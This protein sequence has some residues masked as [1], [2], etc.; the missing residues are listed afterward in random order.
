VWTVLAEDLSLI[1]APLLGGSQLS[2]STALWE[3]DVSGLPG[4]LH[5]CVFVC[6]CV[7]VCVCVLVKARHSEVL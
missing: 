2:V 3:S 4:Y 7:C 5:P 1:P 6:V